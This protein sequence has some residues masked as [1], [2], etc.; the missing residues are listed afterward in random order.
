MCFKVRIRCVGPLVCWFGESTAICPMYRHKQSCEW[1]TNCHPGN[2]QISALTV[3]SIFFIYIYI[4]R[5]MT[6]SKTVLSS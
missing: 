2:V 3:T 1:G 6:S 4:Y 5:S